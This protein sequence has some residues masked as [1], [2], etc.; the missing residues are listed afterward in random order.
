[1][2]LSP[3]PI[4]TCIPL[5]ARAPSEA[6]R[7]IRWGPRLLDFRRKTFVMGILNCT[8]DSF[9]AFSRL[10]TLR[11][12]VQAADDMI[13]AGADILD[14]G[15]ESTRPGSDPVPAAEEIR[16]VVPVIEAIRAGGDV[17]ISVDT[18]NRETAER[19]LDAGADIVNDV[20][21]LA[22]DAGMARLVAERG[23]PV[24]LMHMRGTPKTMQAEAVYT[25]V[26]AEV[27][28][29]LSA[30]VDAA[31]AAGISRRRIIVDPGIGF[32]KGTEDNLRL[33][34][35]LPSFRALGLPLLVGLSRKR[36]IGD[37]TGLPVEERLAGT[38][39]A[40]TIAVLGGADIV[41]V[42][43][44]AEAVAMVRVIDAVRGPGDREAA[45][46]GC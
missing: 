43:D 40:G 11:E 39:A 8:P 23:V 4:D 27:L 9:H 6:N 35:R 44:V 17:T 7:L 2:S 10:G 3:E 38:I 34:R 15:G 21:A 25:D 32:A 19:A 30:S 26:V 16:R 5:C 46:T 42:H 18:R 29:E 12:A 13:R 20:S 1:M 37:V 41:R 31:I 22:Y 28:R 14:V 24:V 33:L 36:F 45:W